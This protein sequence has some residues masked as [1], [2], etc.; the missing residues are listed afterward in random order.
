VTFTPSGDGNRQTLIRLV[1][2]GLAGELGLLHDDGW[3]RFLARLTAVT[4]D[5]RP[6]ASPG[7]QPADRLTA[8]QQLRGNTDG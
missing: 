1:H 7:E 3:S 6:T 8:L 2:T 4:A 5:T